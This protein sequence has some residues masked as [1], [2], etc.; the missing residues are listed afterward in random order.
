MPWCGVRG[1]N[2][3][4]VKLGYLLRQDVAI[5][6]ATYPDLNLQLCATVI[7]GSCPG[8]GLGFK[9]YNMSNLGTVMS[10]RGGRKCSTLRFDVHFLQ[11]QTSGTNSYCFSVL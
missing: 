5:L 2:E 6:F 9:M 11:K 7:P 10:M 8:I 3:L 4:Q 1:Q